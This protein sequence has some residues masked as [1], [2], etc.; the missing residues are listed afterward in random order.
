[1]N[2]KHQ[3][4]SSAKEIIYTVVMTFII[5]AVFPT[6]HGYIA[7]IIEASYRGFGYCEIISN[8]LAALCFGILL[9]LMLIPQITR[10]TIKDLQV[11]KSKNV[12]IVMLI[13]SVVITICMPLLNRFFRLHYGFWLVETYDWNFILIGLSVICL[14]IAI[15]YRR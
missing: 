14:V 7:N 8:A 11:K 10:Y 4:W 1:M 6:V 15:W 2:T 13:E 9:G 12:T 5:A 3:V